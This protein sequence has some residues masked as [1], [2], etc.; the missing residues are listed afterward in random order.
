M[1]GDAGD[2]GSIPGSGRSPGG[3]DG[4]PFQYSH[5]ENPIDRGAWQTTV[6]GISKNPTSLST[7]QSWLQIQPYPFKPL[8]ILKRKKLKSTFMRFISH[9]PPYHH[10]F[11]GFP[12]SF[13]PPILTTWYCT[14]LYL[15]VVFLYFKSS[16]VLHKFRALFFVSVTLLTSVNNRKL[17]TEPF[18]NKGN[19]L[20]HKTESTK[21]GW[22]K[23]V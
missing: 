16:I 4:N 19:L 22:L 6:H 13:Q 18:N 11:N 8:A 20:H 2:E 3:G 21:F 1:Q 9:S 10:Q 7:A 15:N 5:Q 23:N 17:L 14:Y 12:S